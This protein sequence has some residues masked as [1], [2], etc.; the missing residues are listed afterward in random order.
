MAVGTAVIDVELNGKKASKELKKIGGVIGGINKTAKTTNK[1]FGFMIK[2][3]GAFGAFKATSHVAE[4]GKSMSLLSDYTGVASSNISKLRNAFSSIG[5]SGKSVDAVLSNITDGLARLSSGDGAMASRLASMGINAW[6]RNGG[7]KDPR[8]VMYDIADWAKRQKDSG[9]RTTDI[10]YWLRQNFNIEQQMAEKMMLG[11]AGLR[12]F[13][14]TQSKEVGNLSDL[15]NQRL[16]E[17]SDTYNTLSSTISTT[18]SKMV[19]DFSEPLKAIAKDITSIVKY[20]GDWWHKTFAMEPLSNEEILEQRAK[21]AYTLFQRGILS[22]MEYEDALSRA[23][24]RQEFVTSSSPFDNGKKTIKFTYNGKDLKELR[25]W[26]SK[27]LIDEYEEWERVEKAYKDYMVEYNEQE[28][29][30]K[31]IKSPN[32]DGEVISLANSTGGNTIVNLD[33]KNSA[34]VNPDGSV[35]QSTEINGETTSADGNVMNTNYATFA[36]TGGHV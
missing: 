17:L 28:A 33:V 3:L 34:Q 31:L 36:Q 5:V 26:E 22:K 20:V 6:D 2:A 32:F 1:V 30:K 7:I 12:A 24:I 23:G 16:R 13:V 19:S 18:F 10:I 9:R 25:A 21:S 27:W 4:M 29:L 8:T 14:E 35:T 15:Q 11:S